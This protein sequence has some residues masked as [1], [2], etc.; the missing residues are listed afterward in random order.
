MPKLEEIFDI[1]PQI[2]CGECDHENCYK[3]AKAIT[4]G[5][6]ISKCIPGGNLI[7]KQLCSIM[8]QTPEEVVFEKYIPKVAYIDQE[9]C[10][11]CTKCIAKCPVSAIIGAKKF[12]HSIAKSLCT[13]CNKCIE[14][15]PTSCINMIEIDK[16]IP[17]V[18][19]FEN[20]DSMSF[21]KQSQFKANFND[22]K[23]RF[24]ASDKRINNSKSL[25]APSF[26]QDIKPSYSDLL[27]KLQAQA[28][29]KNISAKEKAIAKALQAQQKK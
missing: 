17:V 23:Q 16:L 20:F 5:E 22:T 14:P 9:N 4:L 21:E 19:N 26:K 11:G 3:Y 7:Y 1:L 29:S 15:C 25:K 24:L 27:Y 8:N 12:S 18:Q 28:G 13:G 6:P 2:H 10:I